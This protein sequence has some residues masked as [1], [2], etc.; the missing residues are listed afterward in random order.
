MRVSLEPTR[1][2]EI[3]VVATGLAFIEGR[4]SDLRLPLALSPFLAQFRR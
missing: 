3:E 2:A 1:H 4:V